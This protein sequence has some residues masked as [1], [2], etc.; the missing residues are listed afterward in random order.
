L[1]LL[2]FSV[3]LIGVLDVA[4]GSLLHTLGVT[5]PGQRPDARFRARH[6]VY[7]HGL[8]P[9]TSDIGMWGVERYPVHTDDLGFKSARVKHTPLVSDAYRVLVLGDSFTE[10]LGVVHEET[11]VGVVNERLADRGIELLNA[12][13]ASYS[14]II[15]WKKAEHLLATVGLEVDRVLVFIDLSDV[16]DEVSRYS[17]DEEGHVLSARDREPRRVLERFLQDHTILIGSVRELNR[18][19]GRL[20]REV[21]PRAIDDERASWTYLDAAWERSG[22]RGIELETRY[23]DALLAFLAE[24]SVPLAIAVYPWPD[25]VLGQHLH[26]RQVSHWRQW[27]AERGVDF[28]DCYPAFIDGT[29]PE[30][31]VAETF[32]PGDVHWNRSGHARIAARILPYLEGLSRP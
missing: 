5:L 21:E 31:V 22:R 29:P 3:V 1:A 20:F 30:A 25:Q 10:G 16:R 23:M 27:A 7:H 6:D 13:A 15:Y 11:F 24:Q 2:L 4:L 14:P 32:I 17:L 8:R 12:G 9:N 28:I 26:D 19:R 18:R